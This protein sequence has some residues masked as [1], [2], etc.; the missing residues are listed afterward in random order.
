MPDQKENPPK[1]IVVVVDTYVLTKNSY[2]DIE[3]LH[4]VNANEW[5]GFT[6]SS[7]EQM[8]KK[9]QNYF[10]GIQSSIIPE[11]LKQVHEYLAFEGQPPD[12]YSVRNVKDPR[13]TYNLPEMSLR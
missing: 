5:K 13:Q 4:E 12:L 11:Y 6:E 3:K 1:Q 10:L 9:D 2:P 7:W 8:T